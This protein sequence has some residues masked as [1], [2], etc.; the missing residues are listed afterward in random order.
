M[1]TR[2]PK[3]ALA[4]IVFGILLGAAHIILGVTGVMSPAGMDQRPGPRDPDH[5]HGRP[6]KIFGKRAEAR[7]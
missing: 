6:P 7:P 5:R 1:R 2:S 3:L 4:A